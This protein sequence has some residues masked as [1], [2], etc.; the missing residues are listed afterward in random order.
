VNSD[1]VSDFAT[2]KAK[3]DVAFL[4]MKGYAITVPGV[5]DYDE[6]YAKFAG[7]KV[8]RGTTDAIKTD[9]QRRIQDAVQNYAERYN[10]LVLDYLSTHKKRR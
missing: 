3:G 6:K 8:I 5:P 9:G 1:P 4:G 2:A 10:H 7:V